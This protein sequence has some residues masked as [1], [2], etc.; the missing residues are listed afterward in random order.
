MAKRVLSKVQVSPSDSLPLVSKLHYLDCFDFVQIDT[1][2]PSELAKIEDNRQL[3]SDLLKRF[4]TISQELGLDLSDVY[5]YSEKNYSDIFDASRFLSE[6]KSFLDTHETSLISLFEENHSLTK[7]HLIADKLHYFRHKFKT[8][9][10]PLDLLSSGPSTFSIVGEIHHSYE[11]VISFYIDEITKGLYYFWS[12]ESSN[13]DFRLVFI[14]TSQEYQDEVLTILEDF[15]FSSIDFELSVFADMFTDEETSKLTIANVHDFLHE[16]HDEILSQIS[17]LREEHRE[18]LLHFLTSINLMLELFD[19]LEQGRTTETN[20]TL[21][22]WIKPND[23][24]NLEK[25]LKEFPFPVKLTQLRDVPLKYKKSKKISKDR[26]SLTLKEEKTIEKEIPPYHHLGDSKGGA[27]FPKDV[28]FVKIEVPKEHTRKLIS[29]IHNTGILHQEKIGRQS[30]DI[31]N[32]I[33]QKRQ[34]FTLLSSKI[35]RYKQALGLSIPPAISDSKIAVKDNYDEAISFVEQFIADYGEKIENLSSELKELK[36]KKT[37]L[38]AYIPIYS[39]LSSDV[40]PYL[41]DPDFE[42]CT[43]LGNIPKKNVKAVKFFL[44][45]VSDGQLIF[46][47]V[48]QPE[49]SDTVFVYIL[50]LIDYKKSI[51]QILEEYSFEL[52]SI[53]YSMISSESIESQLTNLQTEIE[54]K[55]HE[56][57][58]IREKVEDK[59]FALEELIETEIKRLETEEKCKT[60]ETTT[61]IW[62]WVPK[63]R[64][65]DLKKETEKLDFPI[66]MSE[67]QKVPLTNPSMTKHGNKVTKVFRGIVDGMGIPSTHEVDPFK[68]IQFTFPLIFGIMFADV[69]HGILLF[70][71]G[72]FLTYKKNKKNIEPDE[73]MSG[74]LYKGSELLAL[75]GFSSIIFGFLFGALLGDEV[76]LPHIYENVLHIEW[77]PLIEP[78]KEVPLFLLFSISIGFVIIQLGIWLR[79]IE[80][81]KY[82]HGVASWISPIIL[83]IF[84]VGLFAVLYNLMGAGATS[85]LI[86]GNELPSI[87]KPYS[88][89][90]TIIAL[91]S[92]PLVFLFEYLHEGTEGIMEAIDHLIA[93]FSNTLSFSRI[94]AMLLVHA[95]LSGLPYILAGVD[96]H[97]VSALSTSWIYWIVGIVWGL[98]VI[99]PIEG[100]F[101][102]LQTL[103][104]HWVEFFS[105]FYK[106]EGVQ[107]TPL[108]EKTKFI[109]Y[110]TIAGE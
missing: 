22:G 87:P 6:L 76:F 24:L 47:E 39:Y 37:E 92:I 79:F 105:K 51:Q 109:Q 96:T 62:G 54:H 94:L 44:N 41:D 29:F 27:L 30:E 17:E 50:S 95:I 26:G 56:L 90:F 59:I 43:F 4:S 53:D 83:S 98:V 106:G 85:R 12:I 25:E 65:E 102:F 104:L 45:E 82:G 71:I 28:E 40:K 64:V 34:N 20:F 107:Y 84:Y 5:S 78:T 97:N 110:T 89:I 42:T 18:T 81:K 73:S 58:E 11:E 33:K 49:K 72:L 38:E 93:L 103:R 74:F 35:S 69:G 100:M 68:I 88:S 2:S 7:K 75:S 13:A 57:D 9:D 55:E 10:I 70:L 52:L 19:I 60:D 80:N 14:L 61:T 77:L 99:V 16:K 36:A 23:Y 46:I 32:D 1:Q 91:V 67:R 63:D 8:G 3:F 66:T 108:L 21:W 101:S 48:E 15:Y 86:G 31:L